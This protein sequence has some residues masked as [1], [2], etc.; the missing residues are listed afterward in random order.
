MKDQTAMIAAA[1]MGT[2]I[3]LGL[4]LWLQGRDTR[5][6]VRLQRRRRI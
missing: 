1:V 6:W 4:W 3:V 5:K 2:L